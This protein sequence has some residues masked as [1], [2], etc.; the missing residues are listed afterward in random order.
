[1]E[2]RQ[3]TAAEWVARWRTIGPVLERERA[4]EFA[5]ADLIATTAAFDGLLRA[6]LCAHPPSPDSGLIEQQRI[7]RRWRHA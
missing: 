5:S 3:E 2:T 1:M 6:S 7:F 4:A